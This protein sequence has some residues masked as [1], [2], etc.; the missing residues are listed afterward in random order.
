[1]F[2]FYLIVMLIM[3]AIMV[4]FGLLWKK[5]S[6]KTI[7]MLYG[8][9]TTRSMKNQETWNFAHKYIGAIWLYVGL[10]VGL[11]SITLMVIFR[12]QGKDV[13]G[14]IIMGITIAQLIC[15]CAPIVQTEIALKKRFDENG[16]NPKGL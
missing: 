9:R 12:N 13:L 1:M 6:P 14:Q 2:W 16:D 5:H 7:N 8:Y 4:G 11:V 10:I 15:L 3:P